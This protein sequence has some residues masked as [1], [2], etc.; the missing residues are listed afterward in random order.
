MDSLKQFFNTYKTSVYV[1]IGLLTV[2]VI[3]YFVIKRSSVMTTVPTP[4]DDGPVGAPAES[5]EDQTKP[6][7]IIVFF[8]PWC[9]HCRKFMGGDD[10]IWEQLKRKHS[11]KKKLLFDQVNCEEKPELATEFGIKEF[12]TI[13]KIKPDGVKQFTGDRTVEALEGFIGSE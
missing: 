6:T 7:K 4:I 3:L 13:L 10:S 11:N 9:H 8:A 12:P 5:F 2:A 1:A